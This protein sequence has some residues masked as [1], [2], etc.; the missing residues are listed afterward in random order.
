M[1]LFIFSV[2]VLHVLFSFYKI[3]Y[4]LCSLIVIKILIPDAARFILFPELSLNSACTLILYCV[5]I[6]KILFHRENINIFNNR[7]V[8]FIWYFYWINWIFLLFARTSLEHQFLAMHN[9]FIA[10]LLPAVL[11]YSIIREKESLELFLKTFLICFFICAIYA[12]VSWSMLDFRYN[13]WFV[14]YFGYARMI[15][16]GEFASAEIGGVSGRAVGTIVAD[17]YAYGMVVPIAF[18]IIWIINKYNYTKFTMITVILLGINVLLTVRRSPIVTLIIFFLLLFILLPI[19]SKIKYL[20][21]SLSFLSVIILLVLLVPSLAMFRGIL[22]SS[23]FFWDDTIS[24]AN[25]VTGSSVE[26]RMYQLNYV[27]KQIS[28]T[29]LIGNGWGAMSFEK[30]PTMFGWE[31][32]LFTTLMQF[33]VLGCILWGYMFFFMYKISKIKREN[34][35]YQII[36]LCSA[37]VLALFTDTAFHGIT[38]IGCVIFGKMYL[39]KK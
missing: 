11:V 4:G 12:I 28:D 5:I 34:N 38:F 35:N 8:R 2:V 23:I 33:G 32:I 31:S 39:L 13:E 14:E 6:I 20:I 21:I 7:L 29:P 17:S 9:F 25:D 26:L 19:R 10:Q 24:R 18:M 15:N 16:L 27:F 22:E 36:F 37:L 3:E 1:E 30:H